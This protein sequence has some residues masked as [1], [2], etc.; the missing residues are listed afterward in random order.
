MQLWLRHLLALALVLGTFTSPVHAQ[1]DEDVEMSDDESMD[2]E[3]MDD[4]GMESMDGD[5]PEWDQPRIMVIRERRTPTPL[6]R[7]A[8]RIAGQAGEV[9][10]A[11]SHTREARSRGIPPTSDEAFEQLLPD[12][13]VTLVMIVQRTWLRRLQP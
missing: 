12:A 3:P 6:F 10:D 1:D 7:A 5:A 13:D 4:E 8:R 2:D 9:V 11:G